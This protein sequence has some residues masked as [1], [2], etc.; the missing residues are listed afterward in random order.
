MKLTPHYNFNLDAA[1]S[2]LA[3]SDFAA[4]AAEPGAINPMEST[5]YH[6][7]AATSGREQTPHAVQI[8]QLAN[9]KAAA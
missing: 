3:A 7:N 1:F 9:S 6:I 5:F 4:S 2:H 8:P